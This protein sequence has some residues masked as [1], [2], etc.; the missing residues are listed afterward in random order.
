MDRAFVLTGSIENESK[1]ISIG[2]V[3]FS[4]KP[5]CY[6]DL[7]DLGFRDIEFRE[8]RPLSNRPT[9]PTLYFFPDSA[10]ANS[11]DV[12]R[13]D[14]QGSVVSTVKVRGPPSLMVPPVTG[15]GANKVLYKPRA[16]IIKGAVGNGILMPV[17]ALLIAKPKPI[18]GAP[19]PEKPALEQMG[20]RK[21]IS[22][23]EV[24]L[25][26]TDI[27]GSTLF[28]FEDSPSASRVTVAK[29]SPSG[30]RL[31]E[32]NIRGDPFQILPSFRGKAAERLFKNSLGP[33]DLRKKRQ[34]PLKKQTLR[35]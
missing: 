5:P 34:G 28:L 15:H 24:N 4:N 22:V 16:F 27:A 19:F 1:R 20:F 13:F 2:G 31:S 26:A 23:E 7:H 33:A 3:Y 18:E 35:G 6:S 10:R 9:E 21:I 12:V 32:K 30:K 29:L 11:V 14:W 17:K 8:V 25:A